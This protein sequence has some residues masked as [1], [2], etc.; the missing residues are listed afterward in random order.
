MDGWKKDG[1]G[2]ERERVAS[3]SEYNDPLKILRV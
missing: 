1:G 2:G 3:A